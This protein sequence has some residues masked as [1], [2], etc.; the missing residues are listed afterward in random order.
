MA[1][2]SIC[3]C[4]PSRRRRGPRR[5]MRRPSKVRFRSAGAAPLT[6]TLSPLSGGEGEGRGAGLLAAGAADGSDLAAAAAA[7]EE[8][9]A[10]IG[11]EARHGEAGRHLEAFQD[12]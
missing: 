11:F 1:P 6:P 7:A 8:A 5:V 3:C 2:R 9:V 12:L 4:G 10:A